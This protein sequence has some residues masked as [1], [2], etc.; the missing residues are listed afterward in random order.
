[1]GRR[2]QFLTDGVNLSTSVNWPMDG[3]YGPTETPTLG[4]AVIWVQGSVGSTY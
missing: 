1:M 4:T 3:R 2:K